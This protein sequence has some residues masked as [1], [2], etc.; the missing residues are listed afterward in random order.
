M[1][2]DD[3]TLTDG[4]AAACNPYTWLDPTNVAVWASS[5]AQYFAQ[6][7]PQNAAIYQ[8]NAADF[9][10]QLEAL[11]ARIKEALHGSHAAMMALNLPADQWAYF[12]ARYQLTLDPAGMPYSLPDPLNLP[13]EGG[14]LAMMEGIL[15]ALR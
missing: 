14:Y 8:Q 5:I 6:Y 7:D 3:G 11:D 10:T 2:C 15:Q 1:L 12:A 9:S 4:P 13:E